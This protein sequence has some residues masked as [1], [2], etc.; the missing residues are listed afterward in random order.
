[1]GGETEGSEYALLDDDDDDAGHKKKRKRVRS[2]GKEKEKSK[3]RTIVKEVETKGRTKKNSI[4]DVDA[5]LHSGSKSNITNKTVAL[6]T[7]EEAVSLTTNAGK[8]ILQGAKKGLR[9]QAF[10]VALPCLNIVKTLTRTFF[11][12]LSR[13]NM[14][15]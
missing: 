11:Y 9:V 12:L 15:R 8:T 14:E 1:V 5:L 6:M 2:P 13:Q 7:K 3:R 10:K 4:I